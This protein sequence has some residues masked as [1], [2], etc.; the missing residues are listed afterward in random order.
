MAGLGEA[1]WIKRQLSSSLFWLTKVFWGTMENCNWHSIEQK[2][3]FVRTEC[4]HVVKI[5][6]HVCEN[7]AMC[8]QKVRSNLL[9]TISLTRYGKIRFPFCFR[10]AM[11][12]I[13]VSSPKAAAAAELAH[14]E[15]ASKGQTWGFGRLVLGKTNSWTLDTSKIKR[16]CT[17]TH[18]GTWMRSI[19]CILQLAWAINIFLKACHRHFHLFQESLQ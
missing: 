10:N 14:D 12:H 3:A 1:F 2:L 13:E 19:W 17:K 5:C 9:S 11:Y 6:C 8:F 7:G 4:W 15:E 18:A 16:Y